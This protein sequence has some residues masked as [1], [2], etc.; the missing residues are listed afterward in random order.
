MKIL[1]QRVLSS[2]VTIDQ[3]IVGEI[4]KGIMALVGFDKDDNEQTLDRMLHRLLQFRLFED[5]NGKMNLDITSIQGGLLLVPQFTLTADTKKGHRA[6]FSSCMPPQQ[7]EIMF[8][9]WIK[10][11]KEAHASTECGSFGADMK[12][13]L[14]NDGP[15]TFLLES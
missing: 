15:V 14:I 1:L 5:E 6:S 4:Q 2:S 8:E 12:V 10:K 13:S 7:A 9:Q 11:A 3:E